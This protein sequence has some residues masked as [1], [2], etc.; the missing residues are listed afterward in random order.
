MTGS[1]DVEQQFQYLKKTFV[2]F[3]KAKEV[4]EMQQLGY[5]LCTILELSHEEQLLLND[6]I[7]RI[8]S[9][10]SSI[11][12]LTNNIASLWGFR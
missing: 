12:A 2:G 1:P 10:N 3:M 11:E 9:G 4:S 6:S 8:T 5:V 7:I